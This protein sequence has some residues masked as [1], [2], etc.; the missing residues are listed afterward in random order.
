M[1]M[2]VLYGT[3]PTSSII[4]NNGMTFYSIAKKTIAYRLVASIYA[5]IIAYVLTQSIT[6]A[7]TWSV[8]DAMGKILLYGIFEW[9]WVY[10]L[11]RKLI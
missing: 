8:V 11:K 7:I 5:L 2:A 10:F 3:R 4:N 6:V 1:G 9:G